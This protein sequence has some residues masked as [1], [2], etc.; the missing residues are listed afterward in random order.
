MVKPL[1]ISILD[2]YSTNYLIMIFKANQNVK[3]LINSIL[4][5]DIFFKVNK[6]RKK[7]I[8]HILWHFLS[9]KGK[10]NFLQ[11]E[12]YGDICEQTNRIQFEKSFDFFS[13]NKQLIKQV[14][15][16][17]LIIAFDPCFI[18]KAGKST[19]GRGKYWSGVA[20]S[21]KWGLD[22]CGFAAVD[23]IQ[24]TALHLNA[25]QTPSPD[26][27]SKNSLT[28]LSHYAGLVTKNAE[29][30]KT[31]SNYIVADAYFSKKPVVDAILSTNMHFISRLRDDSVLKYRYTGPKT[32]KKG[33]PKKFNGKVDV[34]N[35]NT[36]YFSLDIQTDE[37]II[38]SAVVYCNAFKRD[39]KLA[40]AIFLKEGEE[41]SRKLYFSTDLKQEGVKI[42]R[43]YRSRFQIEFLYRD[44]KQFTGLTS[45]QARSQN[46]LN[47]HFN[48]ALTAVNL[49]KYDWLSNK[50]LKPSAFSMSDYKTMYNNALMLE[51]F[52]SRFAINPHTAKNQKIVKEL[53]NYGKIAA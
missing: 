17:E 34:K 9:I 50:S 3:V 31:L 4:K 19:Y 29:K 49:A 40:I 25:F 41:I 1:N 10:I 47:F 22:I 23:V 6:S 30:F 38:Y 24:R 16:E 21:A 44:A 43:Y 26:E 15:T 45:C 46:K 8:V 51:R 20:K 14:S 52:M 28:L 11:L 13:F 2:D 37:I 32:G 7:F 53:L 18:P 12:R 48:A 36:N 27:L 5:S 39:I 33:A 35:I 42:V